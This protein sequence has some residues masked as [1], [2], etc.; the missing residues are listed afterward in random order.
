MNFFDW[1]N[2]KIKLLDDF[3]L[4]APTIPSGLAAA[5]APLVVQ[6]LQLESQHTVLPQQ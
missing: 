5:V 6:H 3:E 4:L 1:S 2:D